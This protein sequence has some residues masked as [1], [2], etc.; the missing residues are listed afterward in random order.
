MFLDFLEEQGSP[1]VLDPFKR[2]NKDSGLVLACFHSLLVKATFKGSADIT[3]YQN[4]LP[5]KLCGRKQGRT[6]DEE[7]CNA[8]ND[9]G[10]G[11]DNL[12]ARPQ[13][14]LNSAVFN[15]V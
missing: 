11:G 3:M 15:C 10:C 6:V 14:Q 4:S 2:S 8:G 5:I 12:H 9:I 1:A 13:R 7:R